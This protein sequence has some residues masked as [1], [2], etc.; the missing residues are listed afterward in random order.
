[1]C[2]K[3]RI[4]LMCIYFLCFYHDVVTSF[5]YFG[6]NNFVALRSVH[7]CSVACYKCLVLNKPFHLN[8]IN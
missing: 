7:V 8:F 2:E 5:C 3:V 4:I 6:I 1:M